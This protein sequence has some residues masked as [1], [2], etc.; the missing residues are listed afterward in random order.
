VRER[1]DGPSAPGVGNMGGDHGFTPLRPAEG[2]S[3]ETVANSVINLPCAMQIKPLFG[4]GK[5]EV[6]Y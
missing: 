5:R 6:N 1:S 4:T 2:P 3:F